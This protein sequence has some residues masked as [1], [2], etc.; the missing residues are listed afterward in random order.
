[1]IPRFNW[2]Y[3]LMSVRMAYFTEMLRIIII[4]LLFCM[5]L[6][7]PQLDDTAI[8][9]DT[10]PLIC[11]DELIIVC[12]LVFGLLGGN[13]TSLMFM[14]YAETVHNMKDQEKASGWI[15]TG[16]EI[17]LFTGSLSGLLSAFIV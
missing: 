1:M 10:L 16:M 3:K 15:T 12:A 13:A 4:I 9:F 6:P 2:A 7:R 14:K 5:T 11:C 8:I 17:G